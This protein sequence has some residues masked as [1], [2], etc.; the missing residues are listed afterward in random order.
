M[1]GLPE[2]ARGSDLGPSAI[3]RLKAH[4]TVALHN[5]WDSLGRYKFLMFGYW[6]AAWVQYNK[7]LDK[8]DQ[9]GNPFRALVETARGTS[10][11]KVPE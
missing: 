4:R 3:E 5:A 7:L 9:Q 8:P 6:A 2:H 10:P 11:Y 1:S